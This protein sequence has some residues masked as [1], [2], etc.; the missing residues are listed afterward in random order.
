MA[1][2]QKVYKIEGERFEKVKTAV[3]KFN[4]VEKRMEALQAEAEEAHKGIWDT[5]REVVPEAGD[6][7]GMALDPTYE[8]EGLYFLKEHVCDCG[9]AHS[10]EELME[11]LMGGRRKKP[12][13]KVH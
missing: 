4:D 8:S 1:H 3:H 12:D 7:G 11:T 9:K 5:L 13:P 6:L 10:L 2:Q